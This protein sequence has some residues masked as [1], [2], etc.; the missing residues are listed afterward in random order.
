MSDTLTRMAEGSLDTA[1]GY[2]RAFQTPIEEWPAI[3]ALIAFTAAFLGP[4][5]PVLFSSFLLLMILD[6]FAGS[7]RAHLQEGD[8]FEGS[9]LMAGLMGKALWIAG[10]FLMALLD[11]ITIA[12][13]LSPVELGWIPDWAAGVA[14]M[15]LVTVTLVGISY[16]EA[17]SFWGNVRDVQRLPPGLKTL[18]ERMFPGRRPEG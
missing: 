14:V 13:G 9:K 4:T 18:L 6:T 3:V 17:K 12:I 11:H 16:G 15:P 2:I 7:V 5:G 1:A 8:R 10:V